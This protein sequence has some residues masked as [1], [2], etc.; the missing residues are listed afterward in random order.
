[1]PIDSSFLQSF[2]WSYF[3]T[4]RTPYKITQK[5]PYA[6]CEKLQKHPAIDLLF[7]VVER[8]KGDMS[9]K[10]VH[11]LIESSADITYQDIKKL[12]HVSVGDYQKVGDCEHL[13]DY[14][15]KFVGDQD[16]DYDFIFW[17]GIKKAEKLGNYNQ[18]KQPR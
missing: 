12:L 16:I 4:C 2:S 3:I 15:S 10:H 9:S 1:M 11:I 8:D 18:E 7:F 13:C 5:T 17:F 6:W 14:V